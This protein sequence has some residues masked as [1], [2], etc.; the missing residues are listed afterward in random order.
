MGG[1]FR[2]ETKRQLPKSVTNV[3]VKTD[4]T[5]N[6]Y[7]EPGK[8]FVL[9]L[10]RIESKDSLCLLGSEKLGG[11]EEATQIHCGPQWEAKWVS[12]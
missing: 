2:E 9:P 11:G 10:S 1:N 4:N 8:T 6:I 12:N 5:R 3:Y 7:R